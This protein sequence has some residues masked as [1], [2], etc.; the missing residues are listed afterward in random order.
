LGP[1]V[2]AMGGLT[3]ETMTIVGL[4]AESAIWGLSVLMFGGT[5]YLLC[6]GR[7][8]RQID[9]G[10]IIASCL[11]LTFSTLHL[12]SMLNR[13]IRVFIDERDAPGGPALLVTSFS[14]ETLTMAIAYGLLTLIG[15]ALVIYRCYVVWQ[16]FTVIALP[17]LLWCAMIATFI[18]STY[19][20]WQVA[21][22]QPEM[23]WVRT[24]RWRTI[25][26]TLT[27]ATNLISTGLL[28]YRIKLVD[29]QCCR[30]ETS[31]M[32]R[33]IYPIMLVIVD[34]GVLYSTMLIIAIATW[35]IQSNASFFLVHV[36]VATI[37][38]IFYAVIMRIAI[39]KS[40][41]S[42]NT[43]SKPPSHGAH[44]QTANNHINSIREQER[45]RETTSVQVHVSQPNEKR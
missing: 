4:T 27:L 9:V 2:A 25:F 43:S 44:T 34:T 35:T 24:S 16:R 3:T 45:E 23:S 21:D 8:Y 33:S 40:I 37:P 6:R 22:N 14:P 1:F 20:L 17:A 41:P 10:S 42:Q 12:I 39:A 26:Y 5:I 11:L 18:P 32:R 29:R 19:F 31:V 28:V 7:S 38:V 30:P 36:I 15:D 13:T